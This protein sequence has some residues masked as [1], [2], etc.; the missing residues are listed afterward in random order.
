MINAKDYENIIDICDN[1]HEIMLMDHLG[2][3]D[4]DYNCKILNTRI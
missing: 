4:K 3:F 1:R 2:G